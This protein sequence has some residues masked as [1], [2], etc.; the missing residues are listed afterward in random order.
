[1]STQAPTDLV[2]YLRDTA[3]RIAE[4]AALATNYYHRRQLE[5]RAMALWRLAKKEEALSR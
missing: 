5:Q 1:M 2:A 4:D 3:Q